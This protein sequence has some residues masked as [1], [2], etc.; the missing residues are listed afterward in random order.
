MLSHA[1]M[2][3]VAGLMAGALNLAGVPSVAVQVSWNLFLLGTLLV[4]ISVV[5]GRSAQVRVAGGY[6]V[7]RQFPA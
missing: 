4:S 5:A 7:V 3:L 6:P 2:F 1:V